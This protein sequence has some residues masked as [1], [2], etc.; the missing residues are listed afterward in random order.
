[1][2]ASLAAS[3]REE[4]QSAQRERCSGNGCTAL[5]QKSTGPTSTVTECAGWIAAFV[6]SDTEISIRKEKR[7]QDSPGTTT[8]AERTARRSNHPMMSQVKALTK[9][10]EDNDI[11]ITLNQK[12]MPE[13]TKL[14]P[15]VA[16]DFPEKTASEKEIILL[17]LIEEKAAATCADAGESEVR[18]VSLAKPADSSMSGGTSSTSSISQQTR[19]IDKNQVKN[20]FGE[21]CRAYAKALY[22]VAEARDNRDEPPWE[23]LLERHPI[24]REIEKM[25]GRGYTYA[26]LIR[27]RA[28]NKNISPNSLMRDSYDSCLSSTGMCMLYNRGCG[29]DDGK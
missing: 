18:F 21:D 4:D 12:V 28:I 11:A 9:K 3:K 13:V 1:M 22:A 8:K 5:P 24:L 29:P 15:Q 25:D 16:S 10:A 14:I 2:D 7:L 17:Q 27:F 26:Q 19:Q 6:I 20:T 23:K